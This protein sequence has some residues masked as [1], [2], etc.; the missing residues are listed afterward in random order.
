VGDLGELRFVGGVD[1]VEILAGGRR[2]ELAADEVIVARLELRVGGLGRGIV[3]PEVAEDEL[4]R[5]AAGVS[6]WS[7]G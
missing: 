6:W 2:D 7:A 5:R 1:G 3:F 4:G